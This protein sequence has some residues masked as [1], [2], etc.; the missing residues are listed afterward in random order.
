LCVMNMASQSIASLLTY[1]QF[2]QGCS[3]PLDAC[4]FTNTAIACDPA[5][6]VSRPRFIKQAAYS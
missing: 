5:T 6:P 4:L 2:R 1:P 3:V